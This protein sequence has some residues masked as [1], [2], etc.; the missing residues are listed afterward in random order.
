MKMY[1]LIKELKGPVLAL[2]FSFC[3]T[4]ILI[5]FTGANPLAAYG[6]M[7]HGAFGSL[8]SLG[9]TLTKATPLILA[10]LGLT[11]SYR[12]GLVSIG[13]EGQIMMGGLFAALAGVYL[14]FLPGLFLIVVMIA[15]GALGGGLWG[16]IPG[17]LKAHLGVSE[18]INTI[19][20]NYVAAH[21]LSYILDVP[22]REPPGYFPQ[23]PQIA[24]QAWLPRFVPGTR[25][26]AGFLIAL[27]G[28]F[29]I[30]FLLWRSPIGFEMRAVGYNRNAAENV[31][32]NVKKNFIL[33]MFLSGAFGG[34]AGM[35]EVGGVHHRLLNGFSSNYGFDA[36]AVA[37]L[38]RTHPVGVVVA[39]I[40][41][42]ALRVGVNEMQRVVQVPS[43]LVFII[44][45]CVILF[46]LLERI[47]KDLNILKTKMKR[48]A[49]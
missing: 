30:Y 41:F 23:S 10:G 33:A 3:V 5:L 9:D 31:G 7:F 38:G 29:L 47:F 37:L 19:M 43:S 4:S 40:F 20:L 45:G 13:S 12:T 32:I 6:S 18:V 8:R 34:I 21:A 25:L 17:Y 48:E 44:Q 42:G 36:M 1:L 15:A 46:V 24:A 14:G 22:F 39:A 27:A 11:I 49:V 28:A 16:A 2:L 35:S 26:H